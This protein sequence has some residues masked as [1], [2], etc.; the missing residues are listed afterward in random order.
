MLRNVILHLITSA[1]GVI[2]GVAAFFVFFVA[3]KNHDVGFWSILSG[4]L[5]GVCF[6]LH[7]VKGN[8]S[9]GRWHTKV[10]LRNLNVV[11]FISA[12]AGIAALIWYLFLTFYYKIPLEPLAESTVLSAVSSMIC[13]NWGIVLMIYSHKYELIIQEGSAPI[14]TESGDA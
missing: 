11:G 13:G 10:T 6:H 2:V 4:I 7:W 9:L 8:E 1:I 3:Y 12:V 14:L 5:A